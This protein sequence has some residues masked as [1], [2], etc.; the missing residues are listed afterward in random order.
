MPTEKAYDTIFGLSARIAAASLMAF[1]IAEFTDVLVFVK[2]RER[3]GK[4][5]LWLRNNVSN[6]VSQ[7]LDTAVFMTLAFYAFNKPFGDNLS[8][9]LSLILP[10]FFIKI[11]ISAL[12]T[13]FV[14]LG[15]K[16]LK[17]KK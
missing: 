16:W 10:Y 7:F 1:A 11:C 14:Y 15:V 13:P 3:L 17:N 5:A 8:F 4:K 6:F 9:L 12:E 2:I